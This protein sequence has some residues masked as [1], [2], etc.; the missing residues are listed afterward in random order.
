MAAHKMKDGRWCQWLDLGVDPVSGQRIR[1]RVEAKTKRQ[2]ESKAVALKE[3]FDRGEDIDTQ[4]RTLSLLLDDWLSTV[5]LQ[6]KAANTVIA[7]RNVCLMQLKPRLGMLSVP[8][9]RLRETQRVFNEMAS[10]LAPAYIGLIK[11]VLVMA[12]DFA[13]EQGERSDNPAKALRIPKITTKVGRSVSPTEVRAVLA[14]CAT[15]RY[16][17]AIRL[18]LHGLRRSELPGLKWEDFNE[19]TGALIVC[20]QIQHIDH[21]WTEI[22][23]KDGS[24]R[25]LTLGPKITAAL[26]RYRWNQAETREAMGWKD[27]GYIFTSPR[28]GGVCPPDTIY[29]A[30]R[31]IAVQA[32]ID[33]ARLH[34]CRH[35]GA[36]RLLA[37][38]ED[39]AT[40]AEVLGHASPQVTATVYAHALPHKVAGASQRL[41][42]LY[43]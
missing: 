36:T 41:D 29:R 4:P 13:I 30:W 21:R 43:E 22:P 38:G 34:D 1:K 20:R 5:E 3:R 8:K 16:G 27:S 42:D 32:G 17:L 33:P 12:L 11:T 2:T 19:Q 28:T 9:L 18:A 14:V 6:D 35:T 23:P 7:Y 37:D 31:E 24:V 25:V 10:S 40:V 26:R 39:I 15:H